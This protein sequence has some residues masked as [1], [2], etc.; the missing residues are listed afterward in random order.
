MSSVFVPHVEC[1]ILFVDAL[2]ILFLLYLVL[3]IFDSH[4]KIGTINTY[5]KVLCKKQ[6][7]RKSHRNDEQCRM[8]YTKCTH[9]IGT[10]STIHS[11]TK[12]T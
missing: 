6:N 7:V 4:K 12:L 11:H 8:W 3:L 10:V 1:G 2:L 9:V 5:K